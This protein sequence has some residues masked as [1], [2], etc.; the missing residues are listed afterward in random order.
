MAARAAAVSWIKTFGLTLLLWV[1]TEV[2]FF[3]MTPERPWMYVPLCLIQHLLAVGLNFSY[4]NI[5][6]MNL[7]EENSTAHISFNTIGCNVFAF[8]GLMV[9]TWVSSLTGDS[10]VHMLG[11]DV[12]SVQFTTLLRAV[13]MLIM[14]IILVGR[15][16]SFTSDADIQE[17]E[18]IEAMEKKYRGMRRR[19]FH[20]A[21]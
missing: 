19:R 4:A 21:S 2:L 7:P 3:F 5:L 14:G 12:Y 8:M 10:T 1:P 15:W 11:M 16:R 20:R 17:I 13:T 6:Y 18:E 9:G